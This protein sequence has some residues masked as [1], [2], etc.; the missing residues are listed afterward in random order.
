MSTLVTKETKKM[1][2][3]AGFAAVEDPSR[4]VSI[5]NA[6]SYFKNKFENHVV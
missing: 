5:V 4:A 3:D 6:L 2:T 1:I